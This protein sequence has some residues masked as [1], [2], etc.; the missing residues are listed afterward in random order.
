MYIE[1]FAKNIAKNA[2]MRIRIENGWTGQNKR[3]GARLS[4][5]DK[6]EVWSM[7]IEK[8]AYKKFVDIKNRLGERILNVKEKSDKIWSEIS[9]YIIK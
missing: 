1:I 8:K 6:K 9:P 2:K 7:N 5:K 3:G 4:H